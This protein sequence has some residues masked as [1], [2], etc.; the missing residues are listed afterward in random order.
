[1]QNLNLPQHTLRVIC[2]LAAFFI[3]LFVMGG[4]LTTAFGLAIGAALG[5]LSL[6]SLTVAVP[7]L[8]RPDDPAAA[9]WLGLLTMVKLPVYA[10]VLA[11]AMTSSHV[12]PFAVFVGVGLMPVVLVLEI[13]WRQA[14]ST[15]RPSMS[16][17]LS[18]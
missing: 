16:S 10:I 13:L 18:L 6:W 5:L 2:W 12:N 8:F 4:H 15:K 11:F 1:M 7:R 9:L 3:L 17:D 14:L